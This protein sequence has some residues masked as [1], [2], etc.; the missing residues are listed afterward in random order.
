[1]P[2]GFEIAW[3]AEDLEVLHREFAREFADRTVL[4]TG[5]D[6][7]MGSHVVD[8]LVE[9]DANVRPLFERPQAELSTT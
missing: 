3:S 8:A 2:A 6:G 7:F 1:M 9:L 4:V 5:A